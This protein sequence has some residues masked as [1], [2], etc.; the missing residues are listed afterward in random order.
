MTIL[1]FTKSAIAL[2]VSQGD[3]AAAHDFAAKRWPGTR[4]ERITK[5]AIT[6]GNTISSAALVDIKTAGDEF[7]AL[8]RPLT[9]LGKLVGIREVPFNIAF[10]RQTSGS[11]VG[12][13]GE[14]KP[15]RASELAFVPE[16]FKHSKIAGIVAFAKELA[17]SS[18]PAA[19][20]LVQAD[21]LAAVTEFS[22]TAFLDPA[23]PG[24]ASNPASITNGTTNIPSTGSTAAQ[25]EA[26]LK[27]LIAAVLT[28][29]TALYLV[30]KPSTALYLASL[31]DT[32][33]AKAFPDVTL[34]G[35]SIWGIPLIISASV[36]ARIVAVDAAEVLIADDGAEFDT[37]ENATVQLDN[38]PTDPVTAAAAMTSFWQLNLI[39]VLVRRLVRW[40]PCRDGVAAYISGVSY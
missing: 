1:D 6:P 30:M 24:T 22:D 36:G 27:A 17:R 14:M 7:V 34:A 10:S 18:N 28:N 4:P 20:A 3:P 13:V 16:T 31:R 19:E 39:G 2:A 9:V 40:A 26:D 8:L 38:A 11:S 37:S 23:A 32:S 21:L 12:W 5:S 15:A 33:G 35:G 29:K 25:I